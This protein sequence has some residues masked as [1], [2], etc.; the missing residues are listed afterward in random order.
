MRILSVVRKHYYGAFPAL[1][2]MYVWFTAPFRD[3]GHEVATFDH[4]EAG[5]TLGRE[6][7][8]QALVA[9]ILQGSFDA[10]F[11]QTSG[12]EPVDTAALADL[13]Q[14]VCIASWN[15]D[16]D[17]QWETT[18]QIA[19]H[20]TF[21][22][23]TYPHVFRDNLLE[24]P[25]LLLSQWG[26]LRRSAGSG[27]KDIDFSFA[28]SMYGDRN[29]TCRFLRRRA[30]LECFG[31]GARLIRLGMPYFLGAFQCP[32]LA[33]P[34]LE[35][36]E[37]EDVWDR[38]RI[39]YTPLQSSAGN[40]F[41]I[42]GRLFEMGLSGTLALCENAPGLDACYEPGKEVVTFANL[43]DCAE[44]ARWYL[45]HE[46]ERARIAQR[47]G[48]RTLAEHMWEQRFSRLFAQMGINEPD[49]QMQAPALRS[50]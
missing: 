20:F 38:S 37:V 48:R 1:E 46:S 24:Y 34:A 10:V 12:R 28:G 21:T 3:M 35:L 11:Y 39:S 13:S 17:W 36:S 43:E 27:K 33:G 15:S 5:R 25:N 14:K 29:R 50:S 19:A 9:K 31:R 44:K 45:A 6:R 41:Q 2:P 30:G 4:F 42:K 8:T 7:A 18:R 40:R 22:I 47:Y 49:W 16:D 23:T 26:C 32:W